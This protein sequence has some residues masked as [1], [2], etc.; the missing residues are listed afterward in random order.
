[1]DFFAEFTDFLRQ[2]PKA[3]RYGLRKIGGGLLSNLLNNPPPIFRN[4]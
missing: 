4:P 3:S 2:A 1:M